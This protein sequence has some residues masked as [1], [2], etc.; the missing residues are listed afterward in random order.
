MGRRKKSDFL[1]VSFYHGDEE[2]REEIERLADGAFL[3]YE[4]RP[5]GREIARL[6]MG[7]SC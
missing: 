4:D 1:P 2:Y 5:L 6:C 3:R 7:S